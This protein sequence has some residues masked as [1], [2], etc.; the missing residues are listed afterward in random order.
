MI[1]NQVS[2]VEELTF[3]A[4]AVE[5]AAQEKGL[6]EL[7]VLILR[8]N[9]LTD[10]DILRKYT[11]PS[12]KIDKKQERIWLRETGRVIAAVRVKQWMKR[13]LTH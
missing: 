9:G 8:E 10:E 1:A 3:P 13:L 11:E 2:G 4:V 7:A 12:P 6:A 5:T